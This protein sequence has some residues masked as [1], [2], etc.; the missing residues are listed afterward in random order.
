MLGLS[1]DR[2]DD[3]SHGTVNVGA[4]ALLGLDAD[5]YHRFGVGVAG[6]YGHFGDNAHGPATVEPSV[7]YRGAF[8]QDPIVTFYVLALA[9]LQVPHAALRPRGGLG[10]EVLKTFLAEVTGDA[11]IALDGQFHESRA[12]SVVPGLSVALGFEWGGALVPTAVT[13]ETDLTCTLYSHALRAC[14]SVSAAAHGILCE[15]VSASLNTEKH[16]IHEGEDSTAAF[17]GAM[18]EELQG[19]PD[20]EKA[21]SELTS[22]HKELQDEWLHMKQTAREAA[23]SGR[24]LVARCTYAPYAVELRKALGCEDSKQFTCAA[25]AMCVDPVNC[26]AQ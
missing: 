3:R 5:R 21:A 15:K 20:L 4:A 13:G 23:R 10:V 9:G 8:V 26:C 19:A 25:P 2:W 1:D 12:E 17:L 24:A 16:P 11:L 6:E 7:S 14:R 18:S 22:V